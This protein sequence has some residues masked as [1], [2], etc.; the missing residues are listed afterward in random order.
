M[1]IRLGSPWHVQ[2]ERGTPEIAAS[3]CSLAQSPLAQPTLPGRQ[4]F[5][6]RRPLL[7]TWLGTPA[8]QL[9]DSL[10]SFVPEGT[11]FFRSGGVPLPFEA[12]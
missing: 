2:K 3:E 6:K 11:T 9:L 7:P 12:R 8:V 10:A 4:R 5:G 1:V